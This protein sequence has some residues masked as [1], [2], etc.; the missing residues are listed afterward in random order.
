MFSG[1]PVGEVEDDP[2]EKAGFG[3]TKEKAK[4][5]ERE[6]ALAEGHEGGDDSPTDHN[7]GDPETGSGALED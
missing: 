5:I 7:A 2:R 6:G 4:E 1:K 3:D